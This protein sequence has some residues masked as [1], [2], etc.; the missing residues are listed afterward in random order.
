MPQ[1]TSSE[2]GLG[3]FPLHPRLPRSVADNH[4]TR[5]RSD[6]ANAPE[7]SDEQFQILLR[8]DASDCDQHQI[9]GPRAPR[10]PQVFR[11][12][13]RIKPTRIDAT[14]HDLQPIETRCCQF[15]GK[16]RSR[17][18]GDGTSIVEMTQIRQH[19]T[20]HHPESIVPAVGMEIGAEFGHQRKTQPP[21][22]PQRG[23][24]QRPFSGDV[25]QVGSLTTPRLFQEPS[26]RKAHPKS[27]ITWD[28]NPSGQPF[29]KAGKG[30]NGIRGVWGR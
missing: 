12:V 8:R 20:A 26:G 7:C 22:R 10:G 4:Q 16:P 11:T 28:G 2:D 30:N 19:P 1:T 21:G 6:A 29:R 23:P 15:G 9:G 27:R 25:H 17:N 13:C 14:S 5:I 3:Q 24:T 18:H